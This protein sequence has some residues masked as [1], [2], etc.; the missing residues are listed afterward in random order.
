MG[1]E[2]KIIVILFLDNEPSRDTERGIVRF[3]NRA[4]I[5]VQATGTLFFRGL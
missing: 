2:N 1:A 5:A 4:Y 3:V